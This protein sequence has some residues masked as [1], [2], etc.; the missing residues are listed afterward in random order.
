VADPNTQA[1]L[2]P[3]APPV[4]VVTGDLK[5]RARGLQILNIVLLVLIVF[6]LV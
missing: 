2:S 4:R 3:D 5:R 6:V 1:R